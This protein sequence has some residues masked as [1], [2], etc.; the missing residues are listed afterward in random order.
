MKAESREVMIRANIYAR[1][2]SMTNT[3]ANSCQPSSQATVVRQDEQSDSVRSRTSG[4]VLELLGDEYT[5]RILSE[6]ATGPKRAREIADATGMSRPTVYRRLDRLQQAG[7][8]RT[9]YCFD[10]DG[11]HCKEYSPA[12]SRVVVGFGPTGLELDVERDE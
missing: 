10:D 7:L 9:D 12:V 8:V 11:H 2:E 6:I 3:P 5:H 1:I 4:E